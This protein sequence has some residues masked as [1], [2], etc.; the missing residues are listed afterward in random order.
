[1]AELLERGM[2]LDSRIREHKQVIGVYGK[3]RGTTRRGNRDFRIQDVRRVAFEIGEE[4]DAIKLF[5]DTNKDL[6][7]SHPKFRNKSGFYP[8]QLHKYFIEYLYRG[9]ISNIPPM[10]DYP[11]IRTK[12]SSSSQKKEF[13]QYV[14]SRC[15]NLLKDPRSL[16]HNCELLNNLVDDTEK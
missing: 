13:C 1:M 3:G 14:R 7:L 8:R 5:V 2:S 9:S 4:E 6:L 10:H 16:L 15:S 11:I 12:H